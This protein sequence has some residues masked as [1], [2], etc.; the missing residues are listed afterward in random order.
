MENACPGGM[1]AMLTTARGLD[2]LAFANN[3]KEM[4]ISKQRMTKSRVYVSLPQ[5]FIL[6]SIVAEVVFPLFTAHH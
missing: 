1:L 3:V 4:G 6:L 5:L 2:H